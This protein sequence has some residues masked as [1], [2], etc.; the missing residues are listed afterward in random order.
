[1]S[2]AVDLVRTALRATGRAKVPV[3]GD[4][5]RPT[6]AP[7]TSVVICRRPFADVRPGEI[8]AFVNGTGVVVH[9]VVQRDADRLLTLGDN[10]PLFDPPVDAAGYLGCVE[11]F[12]PPPPAAP[13]PAR[14]V[15]P[16]A[17]TVVCAE[18]PDDAGAAALLALGTGIELVTPAGPRSAIV[19]GTRG[20]WV[21]VSAAGA[22]PLAA[23]PAVLEQAA[24]PAYLLVG[25]RYGRCHPSAAR[26]LPP[27]AADQ[28]VRMAAPLQELPV[29]ETLRALVTVLCP[30]RAGSLELSAR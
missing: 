9:R 4:S 22:L 19:P 21:G 2:S 30:A 12:G 6:I 26:Y 28:H 11:G 25:F 23:L 24:G 13:R 10:M 7:G 14:T 5:M 16:A 17:V 18:P 1:M 15:V 8:V 20:L 29:G 3:T 27:D